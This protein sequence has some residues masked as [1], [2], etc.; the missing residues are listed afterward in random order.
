MINIEVFKIIDDYKTAKNDI[1][2]IILISHIY[3]L[4]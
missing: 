3:I 2:L 4:Y 1:N